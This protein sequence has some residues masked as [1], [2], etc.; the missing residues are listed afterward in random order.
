MKINV[1]NSIN[2]SVLTEN[3]ELK[4]SKSDSKNHGYG[5]KII[6]EIVEKYSDYV[7]FF[8]KDNEFTVNIIIHTNE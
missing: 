2:K 8:E 7:D 4:S 5:I 6:R 3:P 1:S